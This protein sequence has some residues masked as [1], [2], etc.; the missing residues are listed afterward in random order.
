MHLGSA[1]YPQHWDE[2][3]WEQDAKYMQQAGFDVVRLAEFAWSRME[4]EE[5][6]FELDWLERVVDV[7][8]KYGVK[9]ILGTPSATRPAWLTYK[10]PEVLAVGMDGRHTKHGRRQHY[11]PSSPLYTQLSVRIAEE[12]AVRFGRNPHV[13]AWQIDNEFGPV[14]YDE[15]TRR[16]WQRWLREKH[17]TLEV[18]ND[19]WCGAFWSQVYSAWEQIPLPAGFDNPQFALDFR[20]FITDV[21]VAFQRAQID[22]KVALPRGLRDVLG[23]KAY[24][25]S[26]ELAPLQVAVMV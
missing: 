1:W 12:M 3:H 9:T 11:S 17:G 7:S 23:E 24:E 6:R 8:A 18:L 14:S 19:H 10:Y 13:I 26:I 21:F 22:V 5:G 2:S 20:R 4:P 15:E 25:T 16:Q